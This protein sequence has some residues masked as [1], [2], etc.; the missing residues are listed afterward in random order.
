MTP[1]QKQCATRKAERAQ[2]K[3]IA[4]QRLTKDGQIRTLSQKLVRA[5]VEMS[6]LKDELT[7][8]KFALYAYRNV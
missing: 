1:L 3:F 2:E 5:E 4:S 7:K 8:A 6:A